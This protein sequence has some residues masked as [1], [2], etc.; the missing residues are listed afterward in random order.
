MNYPEGQVANVLDGLGVELAGSVEH[1]G[2]TSVTGGFALGKR[3]EGEVGSGH[4][5]A[6]A[7][8]NRLASC[9]RPFAACS[10]FLTACR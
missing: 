4:A 8:A 2:L 1:A 9:L 3:P 6:S 10:M 5:T 7:S